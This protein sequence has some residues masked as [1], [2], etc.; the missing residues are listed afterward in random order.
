MQNKPLPSGPPRFIE[1]DWAW[2]VKGKAS[3]R[4]AAKKGDLKACIGDA[5][6][7]IPWGDLLSLQSKEEKK[8]D[9]FFP[10]RG[11]K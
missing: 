1:N 5:R 6:R 4:L 11:Q 10:P 8:L 9:D 7:V 2:P 3:S